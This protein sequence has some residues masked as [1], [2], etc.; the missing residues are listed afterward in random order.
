[1]RLALNTW[2]NL[3]DGFNQRLERRGTN[4]YYYGKNHQNHDWCQ[5]E[6]RCNGASF[7]FFETDVCLF[8]PTA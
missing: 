1:M 5:R 6:Q 3:S 7:A 2:K 4:P 8:N